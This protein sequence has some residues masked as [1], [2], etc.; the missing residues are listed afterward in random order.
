[1]LTLFDG[2]DVQVNA[3]VVTPYGHTYVVGT[4]SASSVTMGGATLVGDP[5]SPVHGFVAKLN[6]AG[7]MVWAENIAGVP[8]DVINQPQKGVYVLTSWGTVIKVFRVFPNGA[9]ATLKAN[10]KGDL[11]VSAGRLVADANYIYVAGTISSGKLKFAGKTV[12]ATVSDEIFVAAVS[13]SFTV[14]P[15]IT[16]TSAQG[17]VRGLAVEALSQTMALL[18]NVKGDVVN[19]T[20]ITSCTSVGGQDLLI[21]RLDIKAGQTPGNGMLKYLKCFGSTGDDI[22]RHLAVSDNGQVYVAGYLAGQ[23]VASGLTLPLTGFSD[24]IAR[25][26]TTTKQIAWSKD[27]MIYA[28]RIVTSGS[29]SVYVAGQNYSKSL[30]TV[31]EFSEADGTKI[32]GRGLVLSGPTRHA[33]VTSLA[34]PNTGQTV[35]VGNFNGELTGQTTTL[36]VGKNTGFLWRE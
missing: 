3:S 29:G 10:L 30:L 26:D 5:A 12:T 2:A 23:P 16:L 11:S 18:A 27:M 24:F 7:T 33:R 35:V 31:R 34:S 4:Y 22:A 20:P 21:A 1:L 28:D 25:Y 13:H 9:F 32:S 17:D 8:V 6:A 36:Q 14:V 19:G 15:W